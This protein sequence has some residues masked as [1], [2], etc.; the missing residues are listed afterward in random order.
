[1][2]IQVFIQNEAG[3]NRKNYHDEKTLQYKFTKLVS[4]PYPYPYGFIIGTTAADGGNL[5]CF[6]IT[7][8]PLKAGEIVEC[9]PIALMEQFEDGVDD[10]NVL[11]RVA[12]E[13]A[14]ITPMIQDALT[15]FVLNV[16]SHIAGKQI[17]AGEFL[18]AAQAEAHIHA[19]TDARGRGKADPSS[20]RSSG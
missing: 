1:M 7:G 5:D 4:R 19:H 14:A 6:V 2:L 18:G 16:F 13:E 9:E 12:G 10:H 11:A 17:A 3:S 15:E 20:L 8:R